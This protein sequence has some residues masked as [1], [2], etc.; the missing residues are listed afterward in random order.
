MGQ[1]QPPT[2][3]P[4][5]PRYP[6]PDGTP[7]GT[8]TAHPLHQRL[9]RRHRTRHPGT[10]MP[11]LP[12]TATRNRNLRL[13]RRQRTPLSTPDSTSHLTKL[14]TGGIIFGVVVCPK[15]D[16]TI[17]AIH[18]DGL[19]HTRRGGIRNP[20]GQVSHSKRLKVDTQCRI[21]HGLGDAEHS[22]PNSGQ[23]SS[24]ATRYA[25]SAAK[26]QPP[27]QTTSSATPNASGSASTQTHSTM[28]KDSA[29]P[30]TR[31]KP[32]AKQPKETNGCKHREGSRATHPRYP[33]PDTP[34][35]LPR[36]Y[37]RHRA[38]ESV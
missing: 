15:P 16:R 27:K 2:R 7:P 5:R 12:L 8:R 19:S 30:A 21:R 31:P 33:T 14:S 13:L 22:L 26:P 17:K 9:H 23:E 37:V 6:T 36:A 28:V 4:R 29:K 38:T 34:H 11:L 32:D 35:P 1:R 10:D 18:Q 3:R 25:E 24:N 20:G